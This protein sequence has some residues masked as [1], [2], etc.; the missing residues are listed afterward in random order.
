[1]ASRALPLGGHQLI[2]PGG[3][4]TELRIVKSITTPGLGSVEALAINMG[5]A[6][7]TRPSLLLPSPRPSPIRW[8]RE[9]VRTRDL[10]SDAS[11]VLR[12]FFDAPIEAVRGAF[13]NLSSCGLAVR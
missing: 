12:S 11:G 1:M 13:S 7:W 3:R 2:A 5:L 9:V 10:P 6:R 8:E 4:G